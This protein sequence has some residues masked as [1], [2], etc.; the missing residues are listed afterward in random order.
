MPGIPDAFYDAA[1]RANQIFLSGRYRDAAE[2]FIACLE[3]IPEEQH[4]SRERAT[5]LSNAAAAMAESGEVGGALQMTRSALAVFES[6]GDFEETGRMHFNLGNMHR[7]QNAWQP[8]F[9]HYQRGAD[10]FGRAGKPAGVAQC[11]LAMAN[12]KVGLAAKKPEWAEEDLAAVE[13]LGDE[14]LADPI[15]QWSLNTIRGHLAEARGDALVAREHLRKALAAAERSRNQ[16]YVQQ[17]RTNLARLSVPGGPDDAEPLALLRE[18][19]AWSARTRDH[20]L[21]DN[22]ASLAEAELRNGDLNRCLELYRQCMDEVD[23]AR[24]QAD[25]PAKYLLMERDFLYVRRF[26]AIAFR[27]GREEEAFS[28][29]E[30]A[31]GRTLLDAM[32]RH[33]IKRQEGRCIRVRRQGRVTL[34]AASLD[35]A[36][37]WASLRRL[38]ILKFFDIEDGLLGWWIA[39]SGELLAWDATAALK[40]ASRISS[41]LFA[42]PLLDGGPASEEV[43]RSPILITDEDLVLAEG[44]LREALHEDLVELYHALFPERVREALDGGGGRVVV[45]PATSLYA[46]PFDALGADSDDFLGERCQIT[47]APSVGVALQLDPARD[48]DHPSVDDRDRYWIAG[49]GGDAQML[50]ELIPASRDVPS[51]TVSIHL[52]ALP[53][54]DSEARGI[55]LALGISP[56][57]DPAVTRDSLLEKLRRAQVLHLAT[58][59]VFHQLL[60]TRSFV[61]LSGGERIRVSDLMNAVSG[62]EVVVLSGCQT[63]V[64]GRHPES[65]IGLPSAFLTAGARSVV[66]ALWPVSD[67]MTRAF[68]VDF[69]VALARVR[70]VPA[71][72]QHA[73]AEAMRREGRQR[74]LCWA[75]FRVV[76]SPD[77]ALEQDMS[78][79][80]GPLFAGGDVCF[81]SDRFPAGEALDLEMLREFRGTPGEGAVFS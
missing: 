58:H 62:A 51:R 67:E 66:G 13:A 42:S 63:A 29:S 57:V 73:R 45:V 39:P 20:R 17:A 26:C 30:R 52:P 78:S 74:I 76:G 11:R 60:P 47:V 15:L 23:E 38:H 4:D 41:A 54:A 16:A 56:T 24:S 28:A 44:S 49:V 3:L 6:L 37:A 65:P 8:M 59:A 2:A 43:Q 72:L 7:Y 70:S 53:G 55:A 33:Q 10:A 64:S 34:D 27:D 19:H 61:M 31:Q 25:G 32:F 50:V 71:A 80:E 81:V 48:A 40:P 46:I 18:A 12:F 9:D 22:A 36:R 35:E 75:G 69:H 14:V 1:D 68:M 5:V 79:F 21:L 77:A